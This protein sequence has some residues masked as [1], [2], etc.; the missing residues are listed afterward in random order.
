MID[1]NP[2]SATY[3][4][5][6]ATVGLLGKGGEGWQLSPDGTYVYAGSANPLSVISTATNTVD[7][8]D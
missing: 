6:V 2:N 7:V 1:T 8:L 5:V 4:T 3:N